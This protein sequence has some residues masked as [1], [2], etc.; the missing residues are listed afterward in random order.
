MPFFGI[1]MCRTL[2]VEDNATFRQSLRELLN[3]RFPSM[4]FQEAEEGKEALKKVN[5]FRPN[6][7]FM[8][9][10]L[11]G[12][13]GLEVTKSIKDLFPKI[14]IIVLTSYDFPEYR[15]ISSQYGANHFLSKSSS[16]VEEILTLVESVLSELAQTG[17]TG[18]GG[19][20]SEELL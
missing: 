17:M 10:K 19:Q 11:H 15:Q 16:T 1:K 12:E 3:S 14:I 2:I 5:D 6:L 4:T 18:T 20:K 9:I 13:S 7:V 8:D